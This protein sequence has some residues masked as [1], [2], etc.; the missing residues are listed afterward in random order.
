MG[1]KNEWFGEWFNSKYYHVLYKH[2]DYQEARLFIDNICR[3]VQLKVGDKVL[4][5]ACGKGRH[6]IYLQKKGFHVTGL[7]LSEE[8][9]KSAKKRENEH[10]RFYTH[11]MRIPWS[12]N[13]FSCIFNLFTSFGYFEDD[14]ENQLAINNVTSSL[15]KNGT[16]ILDFLNPYTVV[17]ELVKEEVKVIDGIEFHINKVFEDGFLLKKITFTDGDKNFLFKEKV[18]AIRRVHFLEYFDTA[19]LTLIDLFGDY[20]LNAYQAEKS[21]RMIFYLKK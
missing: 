4:D 7:D 21:E 15:T 12:K 5:L 17:N 10:L 13:E 18:K 3:L 16:F 11:D 8:N 19:G 20:D 2:R 1:N 6:A 14:A 9:I